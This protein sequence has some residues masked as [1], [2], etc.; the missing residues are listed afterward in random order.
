MG[1]SQW[2]GSQGPG[3][4]GSESSRPFTPRWMANSATTEHREGSHGPREAARVEE[5]VG[6]FAISSRSSGCRGPPP[7]LHLF[8]RGQA[9]NRSLHS[10]ADMK[11]AQFSGGV[12]EVEAMQLLDDDT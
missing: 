10:L 4:Q 1:V 12:H 8:P 5:L 2:G 11:E 6:P 7:R 3:E 9:Q